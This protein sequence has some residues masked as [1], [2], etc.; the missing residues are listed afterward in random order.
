MRC[1]AQEVRHSVV[2]LL[3]QKGEV[4]AGQPSG[5]GTALTTKRK[6]DAE[7]A[8]VCMRQ[9][10]CIPT[11]SENIS[12]RLVNHF[13][14]LSALQ[15]ALRGDKKK[16]PNINLDDRGKTKLGKAR[17]ATLSSTQLR[18]LPWARI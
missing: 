14:T 10:M 12:R 3:V 5:V 17:L 6:R 15:E 11:I 18:V 16:F 2:R 8:L 9:L 1:S 13:G 7:P 4:P